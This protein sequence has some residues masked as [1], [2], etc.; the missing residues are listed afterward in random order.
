MFDHWTITKTPPHGAPKTE[1]A[2]S[3]TEALRVA[4][5]MKPDGPEWTWQR[6]LRNKTIDIWSRRDLR[7]AL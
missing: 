1:L 5:T 6:D 3:E 4:T 2:W 7:R